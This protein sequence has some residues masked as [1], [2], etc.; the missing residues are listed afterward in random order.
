[1]NKRDKFIEKSI[2]THGNKYDYSSVQYVDNKTDVKIFCK[3]CNKYFNQRPYH[4]YNGCG[5][6]RCSNNKKLKNEEFISKAKEKYSNEFDY[7]LVDYKNMHFPI[8]IICKKH[9]TVEQ[10]PMS[11]LRY[12]CKGCFEEKYNTTTFIEKAKK[13]HGDKYDYSLTEYIGSNKKI[14]IICNYHNYIFEQ[15][16]SNHIIKKHNCPLCGNK[17]RRLKRIKEISINKFNGH[18]VMPSFSFFAC[19][20]FNKISIEKNIHIQHAMNDG[21]FYIEEL[22]YWLDGYDKDNNTV[23][24]FDEKHHFDKYGN[25]SKNDS[26]RQ[27]EI[28]KF[29]NCEFIRIK[30]FN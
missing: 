24:E 4:H 10:S 16:P 22:G 1:M 19:S 17:S 26:I 13:I 20:L 8:K 27:Y 30:H 14:K 11:F 5:C 15:L 2:N 9:G 3:K 18:Q 12:G 29:L 7:S 21:E 23:Y 28:E 6:P 25:L